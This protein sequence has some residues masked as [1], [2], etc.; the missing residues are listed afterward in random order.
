MSATAPL[1]AVP[2][3][4]TLFWDLG[5]VVLS[6]GWDH[7]QRSEVLGPLGVDLSAYEI[8]HERENFFWERGL[9]SARDFFERTVIGPNP[10]LGLTYEQLWPLVCGQSSV[11]HEEC[12]DLLD[13]LAGKGLY[14]LATLNNESRELNAYRMDVFGLRHYFSYL[15]C[16]GYVHEMKPAPGIYQAAIDISGLPAESALF[17]DD[18]QANCDAA[19]RLGMQAI[20]FESPA[21]LRTAL[22]ELGITV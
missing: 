3:V 13:E 12:F 22:G 21:Q 4:K 15:I 10:Q 7:D 11:L 1:A 20:R 19:V 5:G 16:S 2:G 18:K 9:I 17:I 8:A 6:N 14:R